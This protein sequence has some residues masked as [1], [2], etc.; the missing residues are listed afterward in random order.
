MTSPLQSPFG[1]GR[2]DGL[3]T[4]SHDAL[5][6]VDL[7]RTKTTTVVDGWVKVVGKILLVLWLALVR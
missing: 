7:A 5:W 1:A 4:A 6:L 2:R 3:R